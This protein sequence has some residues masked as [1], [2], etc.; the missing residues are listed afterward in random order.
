MAKIDDKLRSLTPEQI[1][2]FHQ[3]MSRMGMGQKPKQAATPKAAK[4][5]A[6]KKTGK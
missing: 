3:E 1:K 6:K 4:P 2:A 5:A